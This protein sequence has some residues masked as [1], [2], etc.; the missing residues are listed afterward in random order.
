MSADNQKNTE[1]ADLEMFKDALKKAF[2]PSLTC[3]LAE[4]LG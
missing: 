2:S 4:P 1:E 3:V